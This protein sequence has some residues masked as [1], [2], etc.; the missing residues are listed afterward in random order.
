MD[1][2]KIIEYSRPKLKKP[3]LIQGL[4]GIGNVGRITVGFLIDELK[5]KKFA[6]L[7][8]NHFMHFVLVDENSV[9]KPLNN[10]FYWTRVKNKD[11]ILLTGDAQSSTTEGHY[12]IAEEIVRFA[13]KYDVSEIITIGGLS[14]GEVEEP[15]VIGASN[16]LE[17][18]KKYSKFGVEFSYSEIG[19]I[20]GA[21]GLV[22]SI[23]KYYNIKAVCLLGQTIGYP[24]I[25]DPKSSK[26]VLEVLAKAF[27]LSLDL[28][29]LNKKI[30]EM[31]R[32]MKRMEEIQKKAI[33]QMFR[34]ATEE[35]EKLR[36]IG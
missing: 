32:F 7:I 29:K 22:V 34:P 13:K 3:I 20:V 33:A 6:E 18:I 26:A 23:A 35:K 21:S 31:E 25:P 11:F 27:N 19:T 17:M 8:S 15:K 36:Y 30:D 2:T 1:T 12:E 14:V 28:T 16:D 9:V 24:I 4:V 10:E 5:A